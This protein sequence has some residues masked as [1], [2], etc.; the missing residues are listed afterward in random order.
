MLVSTTVQ[1]AN[2]KALAYKR[3]LPLGSTEV[4]PLLGPSVYRGT[5]MLIPMSLHYMAHA[6]MEL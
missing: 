4:V 1:R 5:D 3:G 2:A 6:I